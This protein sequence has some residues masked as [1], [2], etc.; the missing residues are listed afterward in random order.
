[1]LDDNVS[2]A[3]FSIKPPLLK[4]FFSINMEKNQHSETEC[5]QNIDLPY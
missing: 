2:T 3:I 1:M 5:Y 4:I